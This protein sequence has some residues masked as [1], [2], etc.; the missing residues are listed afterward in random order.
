MAIGFDI[1]EPK[2]Q[3]LLAAFMAITVIL[4]G[5]YHFIIKPRQAALSSRK[6]E[7][8]ALRNELATMRGSLSKKDALEKE[9]QALNEKLDELESFLPEHE[10]ISALLDQ[11]SAVE[12][13]AKV[14]VVGFRSSEVIE[15][16]DKLYMEVK[17][18]VTVEA[19]YHQFMNFMAGIMALPRI[20][21]FSD[22][23]ISL[24]QNAPPGEEINEG[25]EDQPRSLVIECSVASYIF[26][27]TD[28]NPANA[29]GGR[30]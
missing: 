27:S 10:D 25:L 5:G 20:L 6:S 8:T 17:Y 29:R 22:L 24:N 21:S 14:Y 11:F 7:I 15:E 28:G 1:R 3:R 18:N 2:N 12:N 9:Q 19:G 13:N 4:Y 16:T 23:K 30:L 26:K